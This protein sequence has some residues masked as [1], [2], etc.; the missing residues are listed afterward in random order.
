MLTILLPDST[1]CDGEAECGSEPH[2]LSEFTRLR[3]NP[4]SVTPVLVQAGTEMSRTQIFV[5]SKGRSRRTLRF[6]PG[7]RSMFMMF[8]NT[9]G[10]VI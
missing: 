1:A 8:C 2:P 3:S 10:L 4:C 7:Q 9:C 5:Q 6:L